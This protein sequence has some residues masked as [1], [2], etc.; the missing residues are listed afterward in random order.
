MNDNDIIKLLK[1]CSTAS[2]C[3]DCRFAD[4]TDCAGEVSAMALDLINRLKAENEESRGIVYT[5]RTDALKS[6]RTEAVK[7]FA[8]RLKDAVDKPREIDG[9]DIDFIIDIIDSL[10]KEM[11]EGWDEHH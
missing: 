11:T 1:V 6:I 5:C 9:E 7:E 2:G 10:V 8:E 3:K 4:S